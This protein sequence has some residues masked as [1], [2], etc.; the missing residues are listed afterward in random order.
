MVEEKCKAVELSRCTTNTNAANYYS[1]DLTMLGRW[2]LN[3]W[4]DISE[5]IIIRSFK[6]CGISNCLSESEDHL[7]YNDELDEDSKEEDSN[8]YKDKNSNKY[9]DKNSDK[10]ED[11]DSGENNYEE[12]D[13]NNEEE[14]SNKDDDKKSDKDDNKSDEYNESDDANKSD[15]KTSEYSEWPECF[16]VID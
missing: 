6:K 14:N 8:E 5:D 15:N 1:L 7:I 11:E 3:A 13:E 10:Y 2:V 12:S 16:V 4:K 9:K